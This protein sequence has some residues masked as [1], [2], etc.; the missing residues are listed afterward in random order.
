[1]GK[2]EYNEIIAQRTYIVCN[3]CIESRPKHEN[4]REKMAEYKRS[5]KLILFF[6]AFICGAEA[7]VYIHTLSILKLCV[8]TSTY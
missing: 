5:S 6:H 3:Y 2:I 8:C 1:M 7:N 4:K